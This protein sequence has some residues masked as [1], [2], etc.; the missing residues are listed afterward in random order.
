LGDS[1]KE[2]LVSMRDIV[3][4]YP[5][6][7]VA[8]RGVSLDIYPGEILGLLGENGAGKTTLM[9]ILSGFLKPTSGYIVLRGRRVVFRSAADAL[10]NG[11]GMVHQ[12]LALVPV[13]TGFENIVLGLRARGDL[14]AQVEK[15]MK[16]TGLHVR[17]DV[18]VEQLSFGERQRI[19]ILR[20]LL[21]RVDVLILDEPTTNL[22]P[23]ETRVLFS[24]L[25]RLRESGRSIIF[26]TH[27]LREVMEIADRIVV[28][29]RGRV[30]GE[31]P[32]EKAEP[33][34]L[35]R[36]M[37]GREVFLRI[38]K[39][40]ATPGEPV[41]RVENLWVRSDIGGWAVK[42]VSFEVRA[43]EIFGIAGVEGNGQA[44]LVQA[45]TGLRR[46]EKGRVIFLGREVTNLDPGSLYRMG[47]AH[48]PE[49]RQAMGLVLD[50]SVA[51]NSVLGMHRWSQFMGSFGALRWSEINKHAM[52]II[53]EYDVVAPSLRSPVRFLSGGNQQ[54]LLAGRE[55]SKKPRL[56]VAAQPTR[57]LD[58]AA[59]EYIRRLLVQL[60]T[61]GHAV[62]LVSADTDEVLQLSD[63]VAVMY[64]GRFTAVTRPEELTEEKLGLLMGGME[65]ARIGRD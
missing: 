33:G 23:I 6:G 64:D 58:V 18:P 56:V 2:P 32:R 17:L 54:K 51:E 52:R 16:D 59:T 65:V 60:R 15:L 42:G 40:P 26:I 22:T 30:V 29:R 41:L 11:I 27:K 62:L 48:I 35:A 39:P 3:K 43:G 44:E 8:L 25:R 14:R 47:V 46:V 19:E 28:M 21:R 53:K 1:G 38:E 50:M 9:K 61:Q 55:L 20:M 24:A 31:V 5:D 12:H 45:I 63:R 37:V 49:D 34:L 10:R 4:I 36:L 57:G 7:T 13:F